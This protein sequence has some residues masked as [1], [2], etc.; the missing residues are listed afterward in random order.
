MATL[1]GKFIRGLLND[2]VYREYRGVQVIQS[3]PHTPKKKR[4]EGTKKAAAVFGKASKFAA[5]VR[6][7]FQYATFKFYDGRMIYRFSAEILHCLNSIK[8]AE[9]QTFNFKEDSF[10]SL[11]GFEFNI[12]SPLKSNLLVN[13]KITL[14]ENIVQLEIPDLKIPGD[15]KFP[16]KH[17]DGCRLLVETAV[18]DL[19]NGYFIH[20]VPQ[21]MEIPYAYKPAVVE[22]KIFEI[23]IPPG[24]LGITAISL[25]YYRSSITGD[26]VVNNKSFHPAAIVHAFIAEGK[27]DPDPEKD[28]C[29]FVYL[30]Q[31]LS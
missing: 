18:F 8:D 29:A 16:E 22:G 13:P 12:N 30:E 31:G 10:R 23:E 19:V 20:A 17:L 15:L 24:C 9:T 11:A 25:H 14:K 6:S 7:A 1:K 3:R 27:A 2:M 5:L 4:T 28:W 21:I 26:V